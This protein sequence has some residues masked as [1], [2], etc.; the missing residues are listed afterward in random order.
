MKKFIAS[1]LGILI[2]APDIA[3]AQQSKRQIGAARRKGG[4]A[5]QSAAAKAKA[6]NTMPAAPVQAAQT[7]PVYPPVMAVSP[8]RAAQPVSPSTPA[9]AAAP[10]AELL[11]RIEML[12]TENNDLSDEIISIQEASRLAIEGDTN[13]RQTYDDLA[14]KMMRSRHVCRNISTITF[15]EAAKAFGVTLGAS[16]VGTVGSGVAVAGNIIQ[17]PVRAPPSPAPTV[18]AVVK[19]A[20]VNTVT[21][22]PEGDATVTNADTEVSEIP[23]KKE[24]GVITDD[25][26][27]PSKKTNSDADPATPAPPEVPQCTPRA[28]DA[29]MDNIRNLRRR[30]MCIYP[31]ETNIITMLKAGFAVP[32]DRQFCASNT[33]ECAA[34]QFWCPNRPGSNGNIGARYPDDHLNQIDGW[35]EQHTVENLCP[36]EAGASAPRVLDYAWAAYRATFV[37]AAEDSKR[38]QAGRVMTIVGNAVGTAGGVV[39]GVSSGVALSKMN[40]IIRQ[41]QVCQSSFD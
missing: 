12:R 34:G 11:S 40:E 18:P 13:E 3:T 1:V 25:D 4:H 20:E 6:E 21:A 22:A 17:K 28:D 15:D 27:D 29:G 31:S 2:F 24:E 33:T 41:V 26:D 9:A 7:P 23:T 38:N 10:N 14:M 39:S 5:A 36:P 30:N 37:S 32:E 19:T 8:E 16:I 35:I